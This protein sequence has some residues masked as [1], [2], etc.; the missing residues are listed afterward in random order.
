M[1]QLCTGGYTALSPDDAHAVT[2]LHAPGDR[3]RKIASHG[4]VTT[5]TPPRLFDV[6]MA[7]ARDLSALLALL[8]RLDRDPARCIIRAAPTDRGHVRGVRR[9][10]HPDA[11]TGELPAFRDA[12]RAWAGLDVDSLPTPPDFGP[13]DLHAAAA[14]IRSA[15]PPGLREAGMIVAATAGAGIKPGIRARAWFVLSRPCLGADLAAWLGGAVTGLDPSTLRPVQIHYTSRPSI[16]GGA[17]PFPERLLMLDGPPATPPPLDAFRR[18]P[19]PPG[20]ARWDSDP[21][22]SNRAVERFAGLLRTVANA[23]NGQR[24]PTLFWAACRAGEMVAA[25]ALGREAAA[26]ALASAV[27]DPGDAR[28]HAANHKTARA[29]IARGMVEGA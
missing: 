5:P 20:I 17:D 12:P 11:E 8:M 28:R 25:G 7:H 23:V 14:A 16:I 27:S 29:G 22:H 6:E 3:L 13:R 1:T 18:P 24:H 15:L 4:A 9:T 10:L 21:G 26:D 19:A 2:V